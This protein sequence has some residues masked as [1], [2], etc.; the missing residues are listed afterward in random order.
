MIDRHQQAEADL[1][2]LPAG[3]S[4]FEQ[5]RK[6]CDVE[7]EGDNHSDSGNQTEFSHAQIFGRKKRKEPRGSRR[8]RKRERRANAA[9]GID[10]RCS[11][12]TISMALAPVPDA[13]LDA[14][15]DA[16]ADKQHN[17]CD[18]DNVERAR[19]GEP[20]RC[21]N[22][23]SGEQGHQ[24]ANDHP[25]RLNGEPQHDEYGREHRG[26]DQ[27]GPVGKRGKLL[28]RQLHRPGQTNAN[29]IVWR[30]MKLRGRV[31]DGARS[32]RTGSETREIQFWL[33]RDEATKLER[34][35]LG[36]GHQRPP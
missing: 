34:T 18:G 32:M 24:N 10:D 28:I 1:G 35:W 6:H 31:P 20:N 11:E 15:I 9:P 17:E 2:S 8:S 14:E 27:N 7:N 29:A 22:S 19:N 16:N 12:L 13:E 21:S 23:Q 4:Q 3:S 36:A 30:Q 33:H 26:H 5:C 25:A